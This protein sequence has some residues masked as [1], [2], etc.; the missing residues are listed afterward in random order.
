VV[1]AIIAVLLGLLLP[2]VQAAREAARRAQCTNNLKQ[3]GLA[4]QNYH[5]AIGVFPP[6]YLSQT[7]NNSTAPDAVELGPGWA[8]LPLTLPYIEASSLY[9]S[10]NFSLSITAP[11]A[12]TVRTLTLSMFLC[13]SSVGA[14]PVTQMKF[15]T[16]PPGTLAVTDLSAGQYVACAGQFEVGDSPAN[17]N[18]VFFRNSANSFATITDGTSTTLMAGERS[19][20]L[21][22]AT[23]VGVIPGAQICT[24]PT[25]R[26]QECEPSSV[27]V[28]GHTGPS[29]GGQQYVDVPNYKAA[30]TDDFWS[31]HPGGCEFLFCDGSVRF[32][33]ESINAKVFSYLATRAGGEVVSSDSL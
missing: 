3:I 5:S 15:G 16:L 20:N 18:G 24:K 25:W 7:Q 33:K 14:G 32:L 21:A 8:W 31:L 22:D 13:P 9:N 23:W 2:A 11:A 26:V 29:P 4:L 1:I 28:L 6:G 27:M 10:I 12:L 19:R 30:G 17:N